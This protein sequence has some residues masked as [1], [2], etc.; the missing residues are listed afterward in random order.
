MSGQNHLPSALT[1]AKET[2]TC[3]VGFG[4]PP[5]GT[6]YL[7]CPP[8]FDSRTSQP[9]AINNTTYASLADPKSSETT[10][11]YLFMLYYV[12]YLWSH[13]IESTMTVY[14]E[15]KLILNFVIVA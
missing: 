8:G 10:K 12:Q 4:A 9:V 14:N 11:I 15:R 13:G 2:G 6:E 3:W 5:D 1:P 7:A